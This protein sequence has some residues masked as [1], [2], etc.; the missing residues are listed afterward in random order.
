[1][2]AILLGADAEII[3]TKA[4]SANY[5]GQISGLRFNSAYWEKYALINHE[6]KITCFVLASISDPDYMETK[7]RV[8]NKISQANPKLKE[9]ISN[10]Q[11]DFFKKA[12]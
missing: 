1:M 6:Q 2:P 12:Q 4:R 11:V 8:V 7:R 9:A 5:S 10:K 3:L